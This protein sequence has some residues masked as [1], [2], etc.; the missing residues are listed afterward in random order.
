MVIVPANSAS[1]FRRR[2][3]FF[4]EFVKKAVLGG[5]AFIWSGFVYK[6]RANA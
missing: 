4:I 2:L 5:K 6:N 3:D 1:L